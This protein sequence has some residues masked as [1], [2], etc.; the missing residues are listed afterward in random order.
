[1]NF[2]FVLG[3]GGQLFSGGFE[4]NPGGGRN[5]AGGLPP[6]EYGIPISS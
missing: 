2:F 5:F 1:V 4:K 6:P 3:R